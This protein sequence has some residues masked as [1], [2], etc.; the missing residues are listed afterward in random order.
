MLVLFCHAFEGEG[1]GPTFYETTFRNLHACTDVKVV[2]YALF[3]VFLARFRSG[4]SSYMSQLYFF[5]S[6]LYICLV[7]LEASAN[8]LLQIPHICGLW[9]HQW[10]S[11]SLWI[12]DS[13]N[14]HSLH[15]N[16]RFFR[17]FS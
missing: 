6:W 12:D 9:T 8:I 16:V 14:L 13:T 15:L 17:F 1:S 4:T 5:S 7:R 10:C 2:F 11:F 3:Y